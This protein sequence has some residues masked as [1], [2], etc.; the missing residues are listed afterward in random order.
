MI[1][2]HIFIS[3]AII[4]GLGF[5]GM[6]QLGEAAGMAFLLGSMTLGGGFLI[7]GLFSIKMLWHGIVGAGVLAL[8]GVGRGVMNLPDLMKFLAGDR[9]R[10]LAPI[11]E[12]IVF[13]VCGVLLVQVYKTW[14]AERL[15]KMMIEEEE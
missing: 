12:F 2:A 15:R 6:S 4:I 11:L 13:L 7:C 8:L 10:G 1:R 14:S 3:A 9:G 5:L